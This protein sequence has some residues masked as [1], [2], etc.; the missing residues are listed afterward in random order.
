MIDLIQNKIKEIEQEENV[1]V[2]LA[3]E[4]GSRAWGFESVDS[5][6][7][8][9]FIYIRK[10]EDYLKLN[11]PRDVI[12]WQLDE[13]LDING[14]DLSKTLKLLY[15]SNP[16][17]FEWL[18]SPIIYKKTKKAE[19]L[20]ELSFDYLDPKKLIYHYLH[21]ATSNYREYLK[22]DSVRIKKYFYVLRPLLAA[23]WIIE[24]KTQPPMMFI[25]LVEEM[26]PES[27]VPIVDHL[28]KLK[29]SLPEMGEAKRIDELNEYIVEQIDRIKE[30]VNMMENS[31]NY[32]EPLNN[33][34]IEMI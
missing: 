34:F 12:E 8:V 29:S 19:R 27:L 31:V 14:W 21:M 24:K 11:P 25:E 10:K 33:L 17:V 6:Y 32:W 18:S 4:S 23:N 3:V 15:K 22:K 9:R 7:D 28:L 13:V 5:D 2:I 16:T 30:E 20:K 26:L 1:E